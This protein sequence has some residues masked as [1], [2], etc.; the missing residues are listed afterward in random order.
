MTDIFDRGGYSPLNYAAYKDRYMAFR[1]LIDFVKKRESDLDVSDLAVTTV[2]GQGKKTDDLCNSVKGIN[3]RSLGKWIDLKEKGQ[4]GFAAI[5]FAAFNG[6]LKMLKDL[7]ELGANVHAT[8][9]QGMN[10]L[11][12]AA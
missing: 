7:I 8:N 6:N 4:S 9:P 1:A 3:A 5:H 10:V 2:S 11:H 12:V